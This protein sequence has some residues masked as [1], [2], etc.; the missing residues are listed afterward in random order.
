M[1]TRTNDSLLEYLVVAS[2]K[3]LGVGVTLLVNGDYVTGNIISFEQYYE[4]LKNISDD[5]TTVIAPFMDAVI[6]SRKEIEEDD[7]ARKYIHLKDVQYFNQN[8]NIG[9][10]PVRIKLSEVA[11]FNFGTMTRIE[12]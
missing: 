1:K 9:D 3:G 10:I 4:L 11:G 8:V 5:F 2:E 12:K 7:L 6:K